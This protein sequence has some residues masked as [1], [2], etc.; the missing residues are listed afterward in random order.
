MD[1]VE[2]IAHRGS[3]FLAPENTQAAFD[4]AWKENAD[5]VEGDFR[6]TK[7]GHIVC[8][9]DASLKRT[10]QADR[11]VDACTLAELQSLDFGSWKGAEFAGQ[12]I[13][14]LEQLLSG[15]PAGKRFFVEVK[16]GLEI[17]DPLRRAVERSGLAPE[18]IVPICLQL[19]V[20]AAIKNAIPSCP[21]YWVVEFKRAE[22][23]EWLPKTRDIV[24]T[25]ERAKLD[26]LD[27]MGT[28]PIDAPLVKRIKKAGLKLCVW[29]VDDPVLARRLIDLGVEGI[30]TNRPGWLRE[31]IRG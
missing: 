19:P 23:G 15:V 16:C 30:T 24:G 17:V 31:Q 18:Q 3:S 1:A 14:T 25:A 8:I 2:I 10:A 5:A 9:H 28:G 29:T 27:L 11:R 21:A 12:R 22:T 4:L 26:G 6:L 20:I 13:S 7:D